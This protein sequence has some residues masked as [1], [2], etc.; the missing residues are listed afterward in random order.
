M[1]LSD[2]LKTFTD[3]AKDSAAEHREQITNAVETAG[4]IADKR[5]RGRYSDKIA[6]AASK[7]GSAV[8]R[9]AGQEK[10]E[11]DAPATAGTGTAPTPETPATPTAEAPATP[12]T[13]ATPP[14][15]PEEPPRAG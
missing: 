4:V 9:F 1:G 15:S 5:T 7:T 8:D 2:K 6:K 12:T 10:D 13:A 11:P 14:P 3:K